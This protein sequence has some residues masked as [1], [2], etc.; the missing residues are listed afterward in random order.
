VMQPLSFLA[1]PERWLWAIHHY[2]GT[3]AAS[4]NFGYEFCESRINEEDIEGLDLSSWRAAFNGAEAVSPDS[5]KNF[6]RRF[7]SYGFKG[8]SMMPVYGLAE[9][10]VG[11][12]FPALD[13]GPL[14]DYI[15]RTTFMRSGQAREVAADDP[16][17]LKFVSSGPPLKEHQI[18]VIDAT[19]HE[20]PERHEGRIEFHGPSSTTGYYRDAMKTREL[21]HGDWLDTGDLGYIANGE[22]Y[23][24]GRIKDIIIRAGRNIYPHELEEVVGNID[25][26]RNGRVA[27]F[28]SKDTQSGTERLI[29]LAETRS[30]DADEHQQLRS[31]INMLATDLIGGPPDE[32]I[33]APA[34]TVLKTS[35]GKIRR[36]ASRELFEKGEIG[37]TQRSVNLQVARLAI[38]GIFPEFKR[39][40][41]AAVS[42]VYASYCLFSY[43]LLAPIVWLTA[44]F[45]PIFSVRWQVM[46]FCS[47]LL[48]KMT[49]I[50]VVVNGLENIPLE[51]DAY[52]LVSNHA[53]YID[54][55]VLSA[56]LPEPFRFIAKSELAKSFITRV[57]LKNIRTEFVERFDTE[58][59]VK[60]TEHLAKLLKSGHKLMFFA[61][62]TFTRAP[63]LMPF[64]LGAF[65]SAVDANVP[66]IPIAT[67][68]TRSILREGSLFPRHGSVHIEIGQPIYPK[69][70][71][72]DKQP[73]NWQVAI[74]L[75]DLS[76]NFILCH[77]GEPDLSRER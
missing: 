6:E 77:C 19:D 20:L 68:G 16:L 14:I 8:K 40:T 15:D 45:S 53:S 3:L 26:I 17:A 24:T 62:G 7:S 73:D 10:S 38:A 72:K 39:L 42:F 63:G 70:L 49:G 71:Y 55:Y 41:R 60:D 13:R 30:K 48:A 56:Q 25:G 2:K 35:S 65:S 1:R 29:V 44:T 4:P 51:N 32:V 22:L 57:P 67:R 58:K 21:F 52:V 50:R 74:S 23:V 66:V 69:D 54:S 5:I 37:K 47:R 33:L 75:R 27:V 28:G 18:R 36:A 43:A 64:H 59:S 31:K 34:G 12:A 61:E 46:G 76:R 11:L 9:S